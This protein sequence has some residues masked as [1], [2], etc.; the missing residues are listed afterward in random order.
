MRG[1]L[2]EAILGRHLCARQRQTVDN[3]KYPHLCY[4]TQG[5]RNY[6]VNTGA[7]PTNN[8][9]ALPRVWLAFRAGLFLFPVPFLL[10]SQDLVTRPTMPTMTSLRP[11]IRAMS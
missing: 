8:K 5:C 10:R 9:R 3:E 7:K 1:A 6:K 4:L 2:A 11:P